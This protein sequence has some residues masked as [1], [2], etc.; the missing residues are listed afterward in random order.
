MKLKKIMTLILC[1][2]L[3]TVGGVYATWNYAIAK[4]SLVDVNFAQPVM[5]DA[6]LTD[7]AG[8]LSV[9]TSTLKISIDDT[10][11][12]KTAELVV[13]GD[14]VITFTPDVNAS[15]DI[16]AN[17]VIMNY[18][19]TKNADPQYNENPIFTF[20]EKSGKTEQTLTY[21]IT[22]EQIE[23]AIKLNAVSLP[24]YADYQSFENSLTGGPLLKITIETEKAK[25]QS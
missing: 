23:E 8:S 25:T 3:V 5:V 6:V 13:E 17:G 16:K 14:V 1:A 7:K 19:I 21:T 24:T 22:A 20:T 2:V 12:D 18:N 10:N 11:D 15:P 4:P 9:D